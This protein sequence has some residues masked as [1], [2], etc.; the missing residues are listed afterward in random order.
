MAAWLLL[1]VIDVILPILEMPNWVAQ[2][3][4]LFLAI[5]FV[6]ALIISWIYEVTSEGVRRDSDV[7]R[8]LRLFSREEQ[9]RL[10]SY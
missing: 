1:Q 3:I 4:I 5:G 10:R 6:A 7:R 9:E 2:L 8:P